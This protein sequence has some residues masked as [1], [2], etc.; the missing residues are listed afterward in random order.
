MSVQASNGW[1]LG[2]LFLALWLAVI[3]RPI[4]AAPPAGSPRPNIL[5]IV[6]DDQAWTDYGFM[7]HPHL[8]TPNLDRLAAQ[9]R[10]FTRG[11]VPSS[12]CCP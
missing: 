3:A 5:L 12:L 2:S 10:S 7:G 9:S 4:A 6:S 8:R 1:R 11:Y